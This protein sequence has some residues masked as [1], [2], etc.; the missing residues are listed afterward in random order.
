MY[1]TLV[2]HP[3]VRVWD[4]DKSPGSI[5]RIEKLYTRAVGSQESDEIERWFEREIETPVS[6]AIDLIVSDAKLRPDQ[7]DALIR[8]AA[9]QSVRTP[10]FLARNY[11]KWSKEIPP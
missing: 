6:E 5:A 10:A 11:P 9:A 1:R 3:T 4:K 7:W 2:S 8:F